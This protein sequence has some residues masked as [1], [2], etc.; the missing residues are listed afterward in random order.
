MSLVRS[1]CNGAKAE[2]G[3]TVGSL[4][5]KSL[6]ACA[7]K[8]G[9]AGNADLAVRCAGVDYWWHRA[10]SAWMCRAANPPRDWP[11]PSVAR[12]RPVRSGLPVRLFAPTAVQDQFEVLHEW[13]FST[14]R[15]WSAVRCR[16]IDR[17]QQHL[18]PGPA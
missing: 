3:R 5:D 11:P 2:N 13:P 10:A 15:N 12:Q 9:L 16:P 8:Y 18:P 14:E 6:L 7:R 1:V 17:A 4:V